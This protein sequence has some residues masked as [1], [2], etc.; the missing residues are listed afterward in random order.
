MASV[1]QPW[2]L[3]VAPVARW[4]FLSG[5][6]EAREA[7]IRGTMEWAV[8]TGEDFLAIGDWNCETHEGNMA[9]MLV[10]GGDPRRG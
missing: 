10:G 7:A 6:D 8:G 9:Q 4:Y 5:D 1:C 3:W 2:P